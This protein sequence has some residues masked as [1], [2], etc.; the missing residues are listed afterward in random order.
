MLTA[1]VTA[2]LK[3]QCRLVSPCLTEAGWYLQLVGVVAQLD[4]EQKAVLS[5]L[6]LG[7]PLQLCHQIVQQTL[8]FGLLGWVV[9]LH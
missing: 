2:K 1:T 5:S 6:N 8:G 3:L 7:F 9:Q 4:L